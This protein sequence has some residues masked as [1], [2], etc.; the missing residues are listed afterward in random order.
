MDVPANSAQSWK[1]AF[2]G[3][4]DDEEIELLATYV[5]SGSFVIDVGA[6]LGFYTV[7]LAK[8]ARTSGSRLVAVE[9]VVANCATLRRN[10][11]LND[12]VET[13]SIAP[14]ALGRESGEVLLHVETGGT[15]NASIVSGLE[16]T[17]VARHDKVG[18]TGGTETA[19]VCP[20]D[21]LDLPSDYAALPCSLVKIDAEGYEMD[22]LAGSSLFIADHRPVIFAEFSPEWLLTRGVPMSAP[23]QWADA[24]GYDCMELVYRRLNILSSRRLVSTR[25]LA[26]DDHRIGTSLLLIP[27]SV[28]PLH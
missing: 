26:A 13:V 7:P 22:I 27:R 24:N 28:D 9:P 21:D 20:L 25:W 8:V 16:S 17:E 14:V 23:Q 4:Y 19:Q 2:T 10:L 5:Q 1:A 15:G 6:S 11:D 12:L 3:S 18:G